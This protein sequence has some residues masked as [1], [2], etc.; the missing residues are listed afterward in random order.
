MEDQA[1]RA[2]RLDWCQISAV[3]KRVKM[4]PMD[5]QMWYLMLG[6]WV[7]TTTQFCL[8]SVSK[9]CHVGRNLASRSIT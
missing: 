2:A 7:E 8:A 5:S 6:G 4:I 1:R 9:G 3:E